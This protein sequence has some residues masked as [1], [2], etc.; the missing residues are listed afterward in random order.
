MKKLILLML[1]FTIPIFLGCAIIPPIAT[2]T[3]TFT[4]EIDE[5]D[6]TDDTIDSKV[7]NLFENEDYVEHREN[8]V[9]VDHISMTGTITN[10]SGI[11]LGFVTFADGDESSNYTTIHELETY[12]TRVFRDPG[13]IPPGESSDDIVWETGD[14]W[15]LDPTFIA[16]LI[17]NDGIFKIYAVASEAPFAYEADLTLVITVSVEL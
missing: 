13:L 12:A 14:D 10:Y 3:E 9:S 17:I 7:I 5:L 8:I 6:S 16:N 15:I 4:Y 1:I 11:T 2:G